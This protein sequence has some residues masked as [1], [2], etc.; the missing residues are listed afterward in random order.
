M[1][2]ASAALFAALVAAPTAALAQ[3]VV[4]GPPPMMSDEA[5]G[6]PLTVDDAVM[7]AMMHGVAV[8]EDVD[9]RIW[10]DNYEVKGRNPYGDDIEVRIDH[11]TGEVLDIDD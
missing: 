9:R 5:M 4:V 7:I 3:P 6:G 8:V 2:I 1:R 10:D 11:L